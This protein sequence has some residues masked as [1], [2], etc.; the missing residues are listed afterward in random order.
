MCFIHHA[1]LSP[2]KASI[3]RRCFCECN[4]SAPL[5]I[6]GLVRQARPDSIRS[7]RRH[8]GLP[9]AIWN[10]RQVA[11]QDVDGERG[12]HK[13]SANPEDASVSSKGRERVRRLCCCFPPSCAY[14]L[15]IS[16]HSRGVFAPA[17]GLVAA[18]TMIQ[19]LLRR[20]DVGFMALPKL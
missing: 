10:P 15:S 6:A 1:H 12:G 3:L 19:S 17:R 13:N 2:S 9:M 7:T 18:C 20:H 11:T 14:F 5:S 8:R 16:L 4:L